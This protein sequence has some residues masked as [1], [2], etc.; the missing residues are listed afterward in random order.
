VFVVTIGKAW[1]LARGRPGGGQVLPNR[2]SAREI[3]RIDRVL[4]ASGEPD[5]RSAAR[6]AHEA[7]LRA[8]EQ[9][10]QRAHLHE[11]LDPP[12]VELPFLFVSA[13]GPAEIA[14]LAARLGPA[15]A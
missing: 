9:T 11:Q 1:D 2:V 13:L 4:G 10:A 15:L 5:L 3:A 7:W 12:V 14:A 8:R 6:V